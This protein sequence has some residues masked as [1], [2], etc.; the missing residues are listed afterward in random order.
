MYSK[1]PLSDWFDGVY[2]TK[3]VQLVFCN[4]DVPNH[5]T[6]TRLINDSFFVIDHSKSVLDESEKDIVS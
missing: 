4:E 1:L 5:L 3:D 6:N 2:L